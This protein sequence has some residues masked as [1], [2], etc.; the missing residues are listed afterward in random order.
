MI[1]PF[2]QVDAFIIGNA[3][4]TGNPAAVM[5]L[6]SWLP[7]ETLRAIAAENNLSETAFTIPCADDDADYELRWFTPTRE[8]AMCGHATLAAGHVLI[9]NDDIV[10]FKTHKAGIVSVARDADRLQLDMPLNHRVDGSELK[11]A[12]LALGIDAEAIFYDGPEPAVIFSLESEAAVRA[13]SP[14]FAGLADIEKLVIV[15]APGNHCDFASRVF[16]VAYGIDEDPVTGGAHMALVPYWA[17][18]LGKN[19]L[20]AVQVS[21]RGGELYCRIEAGRLKL[22]G[23]AVSVIEG[24][25]R[26]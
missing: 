24:E 26:L 1:I 12:T 22:S 7:D 21:A 25:F 6:E 20:E 10:R 4:L 9:G 3:A 23:R 15:T 14:N 18:R 17:E 5:P 13:V 2:Y 16:A 8:M 11:G 19:E